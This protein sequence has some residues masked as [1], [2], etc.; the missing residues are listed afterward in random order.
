MYKEY[1]KFKPEEILV[2]L[3][4]SRSDDPSLSVEEVLQ[5]HENIINEWIDKNLDYKV[6]EENYYREVVSGETISGRPEVRKLL[7]RMESP[8]IKAVLCVEVQRISRGDLEDCGRIMK[9]F[10]Y[11]KTMFITPHKIYDLED[12]YDRDSFERELKR[13]NEYLEYAKKIM[14]RGIAASKKSGSYLGATS[15][16]GYNK[17]R[18]SDGKKKVPTLEIVEDEAKVVRMIFDWYANEGIGASKICDRLNEMGI[19]P[20][21]A[22]KWQKSTIIK[23]LDNELYIG[24]IR[25][26][27][28]S[29]V[30]EV[31]DQEIIKK[32]KYN[33]TYDLHEGKHIAILDEELFYKAKNRKG[34]MPKYKKS[35]ELRNPFASIMRC[36]CGS[37]MEIKFHRNKWRYVCANQSHCHNSSI[38]YD[39]ILSEVILNL[40]KSIEDFELKLE[41]EVDD[42]YEKH[43]E[44]IALMESKLEGLEQKEIAIWEKYSEEGMPRSVFE[45][46]KSKYEN[47]KATIETSLAKAYND[48]P[49]KV[50]YNEVIFSFHEAID[51][52]QDDSVSNE[53][54]NRFLKT[55]IGKIV[56]ERKPAI[57][58]SPEEAAEKG[59]KT[60]NGW[61]TPDFELDI[62]LL[63]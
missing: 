21:I 37:H 41:N 17:V 46:L 28:R 19:K 40:K 13:G 32:N 26:G 30:H 10:R 34:S 31:I 50:D 39:D 23:M 7:K 11:T 33:K 2:Y 61:Y 59:I 20:R 62:T 29:S 27:V 42:T 55:I 43:A 5:R 57:R 6:P 54:K 12:E 18:I 36:K 44:Y 53:A 25:D 60:D 56:C 1:P 51:L 15:P 38:L 58:M 35:T 8:K 52:L 45:K 48:M 9:L 14:R 24:K 49:E 16:Y 3:R 4:K 63:I 22:E 47:E